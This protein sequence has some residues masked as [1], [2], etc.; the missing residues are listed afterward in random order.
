MTEENIAN[1]NEGIQAGKLDDDTLA[2]IIEGVTT[3]LMES[4]GSSGRAKNPQGHQLHQVSFHSM[5]HK[6]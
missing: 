2:K 5:Y 3:K 1:P 6:P 4:C